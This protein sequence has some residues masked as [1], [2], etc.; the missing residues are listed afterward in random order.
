[1]SNTPSSSDQ[2]ASA[3]STPSASA[4]ARYGGLT[5]RVWVGLAI[6]LF[7]IIFIAVNWKETP[8]S[9][10]FFTATMPLTIALALT[11]V[12]GGITGALMMRRRVKK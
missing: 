5:L 6:A 10:I 4:D 7:S 12:G 1:M 2:S 11:F 3:S 8:I 9:F